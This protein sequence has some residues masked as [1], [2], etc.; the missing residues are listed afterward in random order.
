MSQF[1]EEPTKLPRKGEKFSNL[2]MEFCKILLKY[3]VIGYTN[4][5][6]QTHK[7][8]EQICRCQGSQKYIGRALSDLE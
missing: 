7:Y 6:W 5:Q 3:N 8:E 4:L 2:Q 1:T